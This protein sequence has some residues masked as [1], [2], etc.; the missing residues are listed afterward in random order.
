MLEQT[1]FVGEVAQLIVEAVNLDQAAD[2][3]D[4]DVQLFGEG[5]GL[6]SIDLL[7]V[8]L[9]IS[10]RYGFQL[11]SDDPDNRRIFSSLRALSAHIAQHRTR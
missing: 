2:A 4:P 6:D 3:L 1:E 11:R 9:A 10:R 8:A 7:E 5:L